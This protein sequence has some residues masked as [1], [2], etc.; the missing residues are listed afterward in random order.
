MDELIKLGMRIP[1]FYRT[2][3]NY[4]KLQKLIDN[5]TITPNSYVYDTMAKQLIYV[6]NDKTYDTI[7]GASHQFNTLTGTTE[8]PIVIGTLTDGIYVLYGHYVIDHTDVDYN[9]KAP[10]MVFVET[11]SQDSTIVYATIYTSNGCT[12][13][14]IESDKTTINRLVTEETVTNIVNEV[15]EEQVPEIVEEVVPSVIEENIEPVPDQ[16]VDDYMD[17]LLARLFPEI[18]QGGGN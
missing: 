11:D 15:V 7:G 12:M 14:K 18:P 16:E 2:N 17:D 13:Y 4:V 9:A 8:N 10:I 5:G 6:K 3:G 1:N